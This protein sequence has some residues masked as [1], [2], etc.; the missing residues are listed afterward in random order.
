MMIRKRRRVLTTDEW[1]ELAEKVRQVTIL[2]AQCEKALTQSLTVA[3]M[4][5][6]CKAFGKVQSIRSRL[7]SLAVQQHLDWP[8]AIKLF[9]GPDWTTH[10]N[11]I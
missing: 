1:I 4:K 3:E 8:A 10:A 7:D 9:Y 2:L 11:W 6:Y 5:P